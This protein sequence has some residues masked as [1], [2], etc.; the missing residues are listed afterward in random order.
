MKMQKF[1][2]ISAFHW[3]DRSINAIT[4][5][6][7]GFKQKRGHKISQPLTSLSC[8]CAPLL[9][10][11]SPFDDIKISNL[12]VSVLVKLRN[13]NY[14]LSHELTIQINVMYNSW[15]KYTHTH[16][17][18]TTKDRQTPSQQIIMRAQSYWYDVRDP[19]YSLHVLMLS[20][21]S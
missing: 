6:L 19:W 21:R 18:Q 4:K 11:S 12:S 15:H 17:E 9:A 16:E 7:D 13:L 20:W 5:I 2:L 8:C 14:V 3:K 10:S 1:W